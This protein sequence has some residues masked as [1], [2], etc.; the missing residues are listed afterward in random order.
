MLSNQKSFIHLTQQIKK[1]FT[2]QLHHHHH[3]TCTQ[4]S[5]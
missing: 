2:N 4:A 1:M 5:R 3:H